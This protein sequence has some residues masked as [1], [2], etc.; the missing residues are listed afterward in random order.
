MQLKT[1]LNRV[2]YFKSFVYGKARWVDDADAADDR[3]GDRSPQERA[4][5]L[6]GL[7][8]GPAGLRPAAGAAVRVRALVGDRRVL[9]VR[10][11]AGGVPGRAA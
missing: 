4:A 11:A 7:R 3:S 9:R 10:D 2:E 8:P 1:I 5:D 6:L